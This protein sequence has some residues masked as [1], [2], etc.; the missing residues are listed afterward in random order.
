MAL[1]GAWASWQQIGMGGEEFIRLAASGL[2]EGALGYLA[3]AM[4]LDLAQKGKD[5]EASQV[6]KSLVCFVDGSTFTLGQ[7]SKAI[8]VLAG[9]LKKAG[10]KAGYGQ[11]LGYVACSAEFAGSETIVMPLEEVVREMFEKHGFF[12]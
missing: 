4:Q 5:Y 2:D 11:V 7:W 9:C 12:S 8:S 1:R 3:S 6:E 10:I